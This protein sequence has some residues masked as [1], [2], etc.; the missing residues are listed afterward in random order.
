[1]TTVDVCCRR[2][3]LLVPCETAAAAV[4]LALQVAVV[5]AAAVAAVVQAAVAVLVPV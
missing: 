2:S 1:V 3:L 4:H 5:Q